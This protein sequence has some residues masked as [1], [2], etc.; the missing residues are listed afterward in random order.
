MRSITAQLA[1]ALLQYGRPG[2]RYGQQRRG[3]TQA[4]SAEICWRLEAR[5]GADWQFGE[6]D[7]PH[8][9]HNDRRRWLVLD[10]AGGWEAWF[11]HRAIGRFTS[12]REVERA[13]R[14]TGNP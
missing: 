3:A 4:G 7:R 1:H 9:L 6:S 14:R 8:F 10:E 12:L 2:R 5:L 13:L 11:G